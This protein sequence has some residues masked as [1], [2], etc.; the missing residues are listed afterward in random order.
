[1]PQ[2]IELKSKVFTQFEAMKKE[3][4]FVVDLERD[5]LVNAYLDTF[6]DPAR[7]QYHN[8]SCCK[9]FL[10]QYGGLVN[11]AEDGTLITVWDFEI[12]GEYKEIPKILGAI[13]RNAAI[14]NRFYSD[15]AKLGVDKNLQLVNEKA[16]EWN[17]FYVV[18]PNEIVV[19]SKDIGSLQSTTYNNYNVLKRGLQTLSRESIRTVLDLIDNNS[20]YRGA[21]H[22]FKLK[23]FLEAFDTISC[24]ALAWKNSLAP[25]A[26]IRNSSIG[27]LLQDLSEG[28]ELEQAVRAY[29]A[30][31][32]PANYRRPTALV[33]KGMIE[34][35][36]KSLQELG[37]LAS[38]ERRHALKDDIPLDSVYYVDRGREYKGIFDSMKD[39]LPV[40]VKKL[41]TTE[42]NLGNFIKDILPKADLVEILFEERLKKN[43]AN[44]IAP[45]Y[46]SAPTLFSWDNAISWSYVDGMADSVKE[47]IK[48]AGGKVEG[49]LRISL[50]WF[51]TDDL[52]LHVIE[53]NGNRICFTSKRSPFS[54]GYLDVDMNVR[55]ESTEPVENVIFADKNRTLEGFY[56]VIVHNYTKRNTENVGFGIEIECQGEVINLSSE[57]SPGDQKEINVGNFKYSNSKGIV[58]TEFSIES[59]TKANSKNIWN[60]GTNLFHKVAI[61]C[62]SPNYWNGQA[63]GNLHTFFLLDSMVNPDSAR[64]IFNEFLSPK[65]NEHRK[66][67]EML[68][69]RT[70]V[71]TSSEQLAGFGF[72]STIENNVIVR[73]TID[74][75][76]QLFNVKI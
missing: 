17:H 64:G 30:M 7:R 42:T 2:F 1:M 71:E 29:E 18:A 26:T 48:R 62:P 69:N 3:A 33:T 31:V 51:N 20:L 22:R 14:K 16:I 32:A 25:Y 70:R 4:L 61:I 8:C 39:S 6:P 66:V 52:D 75:K 65:L 72:S 68:A 56:K 36:E 55:G 10:R 13:V 41:S 40:A 5:T 44:L 24:D 21:E 23:S 19:K 59:D 35:A 34:K 11:V 73:V 37:L 38:L 45:M 60:K 9:N 74:G 76:Q 50:E 46:T 57:L 53:P 47:R 12:D 58:S 43:L 49:E 54:C 28:R 67:F 15:T 27:T 63:K